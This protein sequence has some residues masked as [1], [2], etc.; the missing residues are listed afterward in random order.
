MKKQF[1]PVENPGTDIWR[2]LNK[3]FGGIG[4][5][6]DSTVHRKVRYEN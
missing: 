2:R 4:T 5:T 1:L 3:R 6:Q